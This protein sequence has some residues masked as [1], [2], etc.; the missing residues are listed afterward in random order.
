MCRSP[1]CGTLCTLDTQLSVPSHA[2]RGRILAN[3]RGS[4][5]RA[6]RHS[7]DSLGMFLTPSELPS[8]RAFLESGIGGSSMSA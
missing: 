6:S 4:W 8:V 2:G 7:L 3:V 1:S 5:W